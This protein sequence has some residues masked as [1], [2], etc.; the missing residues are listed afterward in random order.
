[1]SLIASCLTPQELPHY[2]ALSFETPGNENELDISHEMA[3]ADLKI[4][5]ACGSL[6]NLCGRICIERSIF[7][8]IM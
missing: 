4:R 7:K 5:I 3:L 6:K 1:M 2:G 8:T